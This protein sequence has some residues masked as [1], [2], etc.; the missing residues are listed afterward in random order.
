M[1]DQN[2]KTQGNHIRIDVMDMMLCQ[3]GP[4]FEVGLGNLYGI[5]L[6]FSKMGIPSSVE[7]T[8]NCLSSCNLILYF[9]HFLISPELL[10][11]MQ[12]RYDVI[13]VINKNQQVKSSLSAYLCQ[14][15]M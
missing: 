10:I 3:I 15:S 9:E 14:L 11:R 5:E 12:A 8:S 4:E 13:L 1:T 7:Y 2:K 6:L